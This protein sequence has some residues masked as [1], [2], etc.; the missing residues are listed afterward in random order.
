MLIFNDLQK[1]LKI[2]F[3]Y[4]SKNYCINICSNIKEAISKY[5]MAFG[6]CLKVICF[7]TKS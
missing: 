2:I 5:L 3:F 7:L 1:D 6:D 4:T